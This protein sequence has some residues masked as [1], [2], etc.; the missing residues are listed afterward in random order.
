MQSTASSPRP[1]EHHHDHHQQA[2]R[3]NS[4][5]VQSVSLRSLLCVR[6]AGYTV[7]VAE[8]R[9]SLVSA[10]LLVDLHYGVLYVYV[11]IV[12][13]IATAGWANNDCSQP[14]NHAPRRDRSDSA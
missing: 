14:R 11:D 1:T 9:S 3:H 7:A 12:L 5:S 13:H 6:A 4:K 8:E 2:P 10:F